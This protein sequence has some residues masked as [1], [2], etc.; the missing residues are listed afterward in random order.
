MAKKITS[1]ELELSNEDF[2]KL[3]YTNMEELKDIERIIEI[4]IKR[5]DE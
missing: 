5:W 4:K 3:S 2:L 1:P